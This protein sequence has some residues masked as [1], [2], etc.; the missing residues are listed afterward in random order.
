[1]TLEQIMTD[2]YEAILK[3]KNDHYKTKI[4]YLES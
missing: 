3:E 1:M 2:K 4:K